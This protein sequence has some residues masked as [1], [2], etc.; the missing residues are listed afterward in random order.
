MTKVLYSYYFASASQAHTF[1][2]RFKFGVVRGTKLFTFERA[3]KKK[4]NSLAIIL[5]VSLAPSLKQ[6]VEEQ[7]SL[8][9]CTDK[10]ARS[11]DAR[12]HGPALL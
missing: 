10:Q 6:V 4:D 9:Y 11:F 5:V 1:L 2:V 12:H 7:P 3:H 8:V